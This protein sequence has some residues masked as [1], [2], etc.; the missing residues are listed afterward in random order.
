MFSPFALILIP[1]GYLFLWPLTDRLLRRK[2]EAVSSLQIGLTALALSVGG[3][4]LAMF[5]IGLLPGRW[6]TGLSTLAVVLGGL[7]IGL[8]LNRRWLRPEAWRA[9]WKAQWRRLARLD[10]ESLLLWT[11]IG[12]ALIIYAHAVYYPFIGDDT[13]S[14]YGLQAQIIYAEHRIPPEVWGYPPL[15]PLTFVATWFAAG[16]ANEHLAKLFPVISALGTLGATFLIGRQTMG[17]RA[18][19][20]AATLVAL[21]PMFIRNATL[22]YTDIPTAFPLTLAVF[23]ALRWWE[24]GR[25]QDATL[26]G[27]LFGIALFTKQSALTWLASLAAVPPLWLLAT[28]RHPYL[29]RWRRAAIGLAGFLLP[30]ALIAGP[31]YVRNGLIAGGSNVL[32]VAGL[33]HLLGN[34]TGWPG[35]IPSLAW[36]ADFGPALAWVYA[37]GWVIGILRAVR[38]GREAVRGRQAETPADL[39]LLGFILPYW[40]IWW[41]RFSF[42][43]RFLLLILPLMAVWAARPLE[44]TV[45]QIGAR[46]RL[47]RLLWQAA[48]AALLLGLLLRGGYDRLGG[49]YRAI[50]HPFASDDERLLYAKGRLYDLI[51]YVR[52]N[53]DPERDRLMLMDG[54]MAYYL[55]DYDTVVMYPTRLSQLEGFDYLIHS[56]S[57]FAIYNPRLGWNTSEFY[58]HVWDPLIFEPVYESGGVHI[59]RILRTDVP[60]PEEYE[61]YREA[62]EAQGGP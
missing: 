54:R 38:Q 55:R 59:M 17:R 47:P 33:Y 31:W 21:T 40:L 11:M 46:V 15:A 16:Q 43:A 14:R 25:T 56:S 37:A 23:Y 53:L 29:Q 41:L 5:W 35:L 30:A 4:S 13:L 3:L 48:G 20:L 62:Q 42:E 57:I 52:N 24:S 27:V 19:L 32:P 49:L 61:A 12:A 45:G 7:G 58:Q 36:P 34:K 1:G 60:T 22:A 9:Y 10:T 26:S 51:L 2:D 39:L 6:L 18:G 8:A 50:T 28:R 44:W